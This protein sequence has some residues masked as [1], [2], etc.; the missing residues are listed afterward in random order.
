[1][2]LPHCF[3]MQGQVVVFNCF[4][5]VILPLHVVFPSNFKP[6]GLRCFSMPPV[7]VLFSAFHVCVCQ[8]VC[9]CKLLLRAFVLSSKD[10][11]K[12]FQSLFS[13][14]VTGICLLCS[15]HNFIC[16]VVFAADFFGIIVI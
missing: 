12:P 8:L 14:D 15:F 13:F 5:T 10:M 11:S 6:V 9:V 16:Y 7:H 1:M 2:S 4:S 3:G